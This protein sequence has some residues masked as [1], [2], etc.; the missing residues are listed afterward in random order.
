MNSI[1]NQ[2]NVR[3][4]EICALRKR[5]IE[6]ETLLIQQ[7]KVATMGEMLGIIAHQWKQPLNAI[8]LISQDLQDAYDFGELD[9]LYI[10]ASTDKIMQ[11]IHHMSKTIDEFSAFLKPSKTKV[12]FDLR[13]SIAEVFSILSSQLK[14]HDISYKINCKIHNMKFGNHIEFQN[15]FEILSCQAKDII[16]YPNEFK[17]VLINLINNAKD[18]II[19]S[20]VNGILNRGEG[21]INVNI[22][23]NHA[24][25]DGSDKDNLTLEIKDN[26]GGIADEIK[27]RIFEPY[28][29]TKTDAKGSGIG[30]YMAKIIIEKYMGGKIYCDN[31]ED[32]AVFTIELSND[33]LQLP[34]NTFK[35][36]G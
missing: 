26:G 36:T 24:T 34:A 16:G 21:E 19:E 15:C 18:K 23:K 4:Q 14:H 25:Y 1:H 3:E 28:F 11:Q 30:L 10:D 31:V 7:S 33:A 35:R 2:N 6:L 20:M 22:D 12:I 32:G 29:T 5:V 17:H 8:S 13:L 9:K 27:D